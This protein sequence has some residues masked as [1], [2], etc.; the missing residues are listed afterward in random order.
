MRDWYYL[1]ELPEQVKDMVIEA[2]MDHYEE[3][4]DDGET[5]TREEAVAILTDDSEEPQKYTFEQHELT[6]AYY[7][8]HYDPDAPEDWD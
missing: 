6:G 1:H 2:A 5:I 7:W 8:S 4:S 3:Y